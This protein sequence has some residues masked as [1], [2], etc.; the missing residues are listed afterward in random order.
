VLELIE[1]LV[2]ASIVLRSYSSI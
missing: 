2:E 1:V